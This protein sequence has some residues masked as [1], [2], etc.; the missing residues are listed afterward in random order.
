[1]KRTLTIGT[2][3]ITHDF[4]SRRSNQNTGDGKNGDKTANNS[5]KSDHEEENRAAILASVRGPIIR[6]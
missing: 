6:S 3:Y 5:S 2:A 1:M 4:N